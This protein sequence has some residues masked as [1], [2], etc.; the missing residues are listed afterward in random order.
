M[1]ERANVRIDLLTAD[2]QHADLARFDTLIDVRSPGEFAQ[3]HIPGAI[4]LPVLSDAERAEVGT[5][6]KQ[7]S[8]FEAKKRGGALVARNIAAHIEST[9]HHQP[10]SW[11]PLVYC[12]RGGSRSGAMT[13]ILR[14]IGW[15]AQ[16]LEGGYKSFRAVVRRDLDSLPS[17][18][19]FKV[20]CGR[21]GSGKSRL[22]QAL[23]DAGAQ[24]LDLEALA[25]HRGSVLGDLPDDP[26]PPQ[27]VFETAIWSALHHMDPTRPIWVEAESKRVGLLRVPDALM[28]AMRAGQCVL[29][30]TEPAARVALLQE[31]YRHLIEN[32]PLLSQKLDCLKGLHPNE[33]IDGW[34]TLADRGEWAALVEDLLSHH[35]DPA[36]GKS[37]YRNY[38]NIR[39]AAI[40]RVSDASARGLAGLAR[41]LG[42]ER[43]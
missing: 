25:R 32:T 11:T 9:L 20:V 40:V 29:L 1:R 3:D 22:L 31:D 2:F 30:D 7:S 27:K 38:A 33:R 43:P 12:W 15:S 4:N 14:A 42:S 8:A 16:Q 6:H 17:V 39:N 35:Y 41:Q 10:R 36:Y 19:Q 26:Q 23:Q 34:K 5:L 37:M 13:H 21:T 24:V 28:D 18:L